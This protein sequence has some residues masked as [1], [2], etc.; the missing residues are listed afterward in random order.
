MILVAIMVAFFVAAIALVRVLSA[1]IERDAGPEGFPGETPAMS[2]GT[3]ADD[4]VTG[5]GRPG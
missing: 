3:A 1:M 4:A 5:P 2:R